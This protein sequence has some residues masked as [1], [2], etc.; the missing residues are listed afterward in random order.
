MIAV[1]LGVVALGRGIALHGFMLPSAIGGLGLGVMA[2]ALAVPHGGGE[3]AIA[4]FGVLL[5]A[6]GH[7][8]NRRAGI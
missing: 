4:A 8:L 3:I 2:G 7:D 5:V 1:L 6:M